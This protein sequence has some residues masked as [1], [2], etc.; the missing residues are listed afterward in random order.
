M[1]E[2]LFDSVIGNTVN[3]T[4]FLICLVNSLVLGFCVALYYRR[5]GSHSSAFVC[6]LAILPIVIQVVIMM[7]NGNL[8]A[9]VAVAGA[10]SLVRF[11]SAQG[12]ANEICGIFI[13]M[14]AGLAT[15]MGYV[16]IA[17]LFVMLVAVAALLLNVLSFTSSDADL[18]LKITIPEHLDFE[19]E[20]API[21]TRYTK[22][23]NLMQIKTT[24]MGS[25]YK[26]KYKVTLKGLGSQKK[27]ID[28][29]RTKNSNLDISLQ[30]AALF[31]K[32]GL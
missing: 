8:G 14:A 25:L 31:D 5:D 20:F 24:N 23:Y 27:F 12:S 9:G 6:T 15:G 16:G 1:M 28:E 7:V 32:E 17:V 13:C 10:F 2:L 18:L 30:S 11:R 22:A 21:F 26:L 19:G 4:A 3:M 29:L